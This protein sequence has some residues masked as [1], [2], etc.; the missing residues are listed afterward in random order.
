MTIES[1]VGQGP[2]S[3]GSAG[4][5]HR[6]VVVGGGFGGL[7]AVREL[8]DADVDVTL[9]DR[10]NHHLFQPLLY[11]VAAG[12]LSPGL[13]APALRGIVKEQDNVRV[14]LADVHTLDLDAKV[15]HAKG[16]DDRPVDL[17]Y[18]T[19]IV[20]AGATH[21]YFGKDEFAE[22]APG[23][24]TIEDARFTR[25]AILS[26]FEMAEEAADPTERA[27]WLTFVVIGAGPTGVELVG[28]IAEL[29]HTVLPRDYRSINTREARIVLLEGAPSV[30]PPFDKKLQAYTHRALEK[31]GVEIH[32]NS[33]AIAMDH[34]SITFKAPEGVQTIRARTRIWAAGVAASPLAKQLAEKSGAGD[35][36]RGPN[37]GEP[38]LHRAGAPRGVRDRRHG[39][40]EQ[41][42]RGGAAGAAGGRVRRQG[43]QEAAGG[44]DGRRAV[45][46]LRQ[47]LD[48]DDRLP[49]GGGGR[50][51]VQ[52]HGRARLRDVGV[53]PR[54]LPGRLGQPP[55]HAVPVAAELGVHQ[56]PQPPHHH[57]QP[58]EEGPPHGSHLLDRSPSAGDP[59]RGEPA[60]RP[61]PSRWRCRTGRLRGRVRGRDGSGRA[62]A[63][64]GLRRPH[65]VR[66]HGDARAAARPGPRLEDVGATGVSV[67]DHSLLH[68]R[69]P[70][71]HGRGRRRLRPADH[72]RRGG[73]HVG[74][75]GRADR[76]REL[77]LGA[78]GLLLRSSPSSP[79]C[80]AA[81]G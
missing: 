74:S 5:R 61:E 36:P 62:A 60:G 59:A 37:P 19:L 12:I 77:G 54:G 20:A 55:S 51:Q 21:S 4:H 11:Q 57:L 64:A 9:V 69:R 22:Y 52:G 29:A 14:L 18:D 28:Q 27:E 56:E 79:S 16:P 66:R 63:G 10:T 17:P 58:C 7:N 2:I 30:L 13:I 73:R 72:A 8:A 23:M 31:M 34:E 42:P 35:R 32:T 71:P 46:V 49:V 80:S 81:T 26:K 68:L 3:Q 1:P 67:S 25:D 48:G 24:K 44:R 76:R 15:V 38:R 40:A 6:V 39:V 78:P 47:G 75:A 50:V 65:P 70:P 41:A 53:H 43:D 45:Q 33:L